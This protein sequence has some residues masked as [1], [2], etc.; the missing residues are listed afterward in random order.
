[1]SLINL[2]RLDLKNKWDLTPFI[3]IGIV[4]AVLYAISSVFF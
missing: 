3:L 1:M 2:R 4:V